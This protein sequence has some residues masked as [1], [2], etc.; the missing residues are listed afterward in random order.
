M[1]TIALKA[2]VRCGYVDCGCMHAC[3]SRLPAG[4]VMSSR[5]VLIVERLRLCCWQCASGMEPPG[6]GCEFPEVPSRDGSGCCFP[7]IEDI[8]DE[9]SRE[10][11]EIQAT[12]H[13]SFAP[14]FG[15]NVT[16]LDFETCGYARPRCVLAVDACTNVTRAEDGSV[17]PAQ[18]A[19]NGP[20]CGVADYD[21]QGEV[22]QMCVPLGGPGRSA[23]DC[24]MNEWMAMEMERAMAEQ[25]EQT[26]TPGSDQPTCD[27]AA[28][29]QAASDAVSSADPTILSSSPVYHACAEV[30]HTIGDIQIAASCP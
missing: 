6:D 11:R 15:D 29:M 27:F 1:G 19:A 18:C 7:T 16:I 3:A 30:A 10:M 28:L 24:Y 26:H 25:H 13:D 2:R 14:C 12:C 17:D 23:F 22:T 20:E 21:M 4:I 9:Q 5:Q 8:P